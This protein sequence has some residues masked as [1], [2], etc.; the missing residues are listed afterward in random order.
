M[1]GHVRHH[2]G[3]VEQDARHDRLAEPAQHGVRPAVADDHPQQPRRRGQ[4]GQRRQ[5]VAQH[6]V[7]EHVDRVQVVLADVVDRPVA[8]RPQQGHRAGEAPH[9]A[10]GHDRLADADGV[11]SD[12]ADHVHVRR[13][14]ARRRAARRRGGPGSGTGPPRPERAPSKSAPLGARTRSAR[15]SPAARRDGARCQLPKKWNV[16]RATDVHEHRQAEAEVEEEAEQ[17]V[18]ELQVHEVADDGDELGHHQDQQ[19][20]QEQRPDV[21]VAERDLGR[22]HHGQDQGDEDVLL[23]GRAVVAL[24]VLVGREVLTDV[25]MIA[26]VDVGGHGV[27]PIM[28]GS[29]RRA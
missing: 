12:E 13:G 1:P 9:V 14:Q 28:P 8:G 7:L 29:G 3:H 27:P 10:P 22:G 24:A 26:G 6:H 20:G 5:E 2:D 16:A 4:Q 17:L 19:R 18:V 23:V 11:G 15:S 25:R 21:D